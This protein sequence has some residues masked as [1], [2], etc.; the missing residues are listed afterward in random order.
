[1][2]IFCFLSRKDT[3]FRGVPLRTGASALPGPAAPALASSPVAPSRSG[4]AD[5]SFP[6]LLFFALCRCACC[7]WV[8]AAAPAA[9]WSFAV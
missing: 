1:M 7:S 3:P 9:R 6:S 2:Q 4:A 8:A 5:S